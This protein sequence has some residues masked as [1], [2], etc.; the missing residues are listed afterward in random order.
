MWTYTL[1][2]LESGKDAV[3]YIWL[4]PP[5][6]KPTIYFNPTT[7]KKDQAVSIMAVGFTPDEN[8]QVTI[9]S[10]KGPAFT[11]NGDIPAG[12]GGGY[13]DEFVLT[14]TIPAQYQTVGVWTYSVI[15]KAT[16]TKF[17][18]GTFTITD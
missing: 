9:K 6:S 10:P 16:P 1:S 13:I 11:Y 3:I 17:V 2:G 5:V 8:L 4:D 12:A 15:S 14:R 7:A 18:A